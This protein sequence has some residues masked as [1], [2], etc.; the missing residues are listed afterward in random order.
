MTT[1]D[2]LI[3]KVPK[4]DQ[5]IVLV[6]QS[7][8]FPE[9]AFLR[10]LLAVSRWNARMTNQA[11]FEII[12]G[13]LRIPQHNLGEFGLNTALESIDKDFLLNLFPFFNWCPLHR[14]SSWFTH[15]LKNLKI[16]NTHFVIFKHKSQNFSYDI[17]KN[18]GFR[19]DAAKILYFR[20]FETFIKA[21]KTSKV[22]VAILIRLTGDLGVLQR[23]FEVVKPLQTS[24]IGKKTNSQR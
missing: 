9:A 11:P 16:A 24:S 20:D 18:N 19:S 8:H 5:L 7:E 15:Q 14:P 2:R 21:A 4:V 12:V 17:I 3:L 13:T 23:K 1:S 22:T 10:Q 6:D